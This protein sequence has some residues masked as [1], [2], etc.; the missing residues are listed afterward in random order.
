MSIMKVSPSKMELKIQHQ[1]DHE[2]FW[3]LAIELEVDA[4][5]YKVFKQ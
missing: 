1:K 4:F 2:I 5:V 3:Y